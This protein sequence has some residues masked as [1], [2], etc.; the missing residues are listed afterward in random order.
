MAQWTLDIST[1]KVE[2]EASH[3]QLFGYEDLLPHW[4]IEF[5]MAHMVAEDQPA[6]IETM[7]ATIE[8]KENFD[9]KYRIQWPDGSIHTL[10]SVGSF[11]RDESGISIGK[12]IGASELQD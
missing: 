8:K 3:D 10:H 1:R 9:V 2:R 5:F 4:N 11:H 7:K 12:V 6:F